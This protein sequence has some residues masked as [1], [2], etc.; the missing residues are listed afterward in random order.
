MGFALLASVCAYGKAYDTG[1]KECNP[2]IPGLQA[3]HQFDRCAGKVHLA[4]H[5]GCAKSF[6]SGKDQNPWK[7]HLMGPEMRASMCGSI[8]VSCID[9]ANRMAYLGCE[10]DFN[11]WKFIVNVDNLDCVEG[12]VSTYVKP[13]PGF[14]PA[15]T[16]PVIQSSTLP[17]GSSIIAAGH[18]APAALQQCVINAAKK[19]YAEVQ[20]KVQDQDQLGFY[21]MYHKM[22]ATDL[23]AALLRSR[24]KLRARSARAFALFGPECDHEPKFSKGKG[25]L[26]TD[27]PQ[28]QRTCKLLS[29]ATMM[30]NHLDPENLTPDE[31]RKRFLDESNSF[32][33]S[34]VL[35][36]FAEIGMRTLMY[37]GLPDAT[38][39]AIFPKLNMK[40]RA[41][42][43]DRLEKAS[44]LSSSG[45]FVELHNGYVFGGSRMSGDKNSIDCSDFISSVYDLK[46]PVTD[47]SGKTSLREPTTLQLQQ[48][49][50]FVSKESKARPPAPWD[51]YIPCFQP[52]NLRAGQRPQPGDIV[53]QRANGEGHV[54]MVESYN[55]D[56]DPD[57][58][59]TIEAF[60]GGMGT[61][62]PNMRPLFDQRCRN[63]APDDV[64]SVRSDITVIR[65]VEG[66]GCPAHPDDT[67]C[68]SAN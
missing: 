37:E 53:V 68:A 55:A 15:A 46:A 9:S 47:E 32:A 27:I 7:S 45:T 34:R 63:S 54:V 36:D 25:V 67:A 65:F 51:R 19:K 48:I 23:K 16:C 59:K 5:S 4:N 20:T 3:S 31:A 12:N 8:V 24:D 1:V 22:S 21:D 13:L 62:G 2:A 10:G 61:L 17:V 38:Q 39:A 29:E 64:P 50:K 6:E 41:G 33:Q 60:G 43:F 18:L 44:G 35:V 11:S 40:R 26:D 66:A 57:S 58:V 28:G 42:E 56:E 52:V 14:A 30:A 49:A